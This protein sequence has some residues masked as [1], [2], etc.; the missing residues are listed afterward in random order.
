MS[1]CKTTKQTLHGPNEIVVDG[2][3]AEMTLYDKKGN[4]VAKTL[5]DTSMIEA[6]KEHRWYLNDN[7]YVRN[8][9]GPKRLY[10][11]QI[12]MGEPPKN[13]EIDHINRNRLDNRKEN[14]RFATRQINVLNCGLQKDN[15]SGI[16][17]VYWN[18]TKKK[19]QAYIRVNGKQIYLGRFKRKRD[20]SKARKAAEKKYRSK[21]EEMLE[22]EQNGSSDKNSPA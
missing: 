5:I 10:L 18:R 17:G 3:I 12:I 4:S 8:N 14:L 11:H 6:V 7:G 15:M 19:W 9:A 20:A 22:E 1:R 13:K 2:D 21:I 16:T